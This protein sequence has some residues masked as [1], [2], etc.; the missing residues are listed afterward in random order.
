M[1]GG[2]KGRYIRGR[3]RVDMDGKVI[4][5][6]GLVTTPIRR[7]GCIYKEREEGLDVRGGREDI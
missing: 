5:A 1:R 2:G 3:E 4:R 7:R 6:R